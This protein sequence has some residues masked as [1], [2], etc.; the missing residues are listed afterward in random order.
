MAN[1]LYGAG[2][3]LMECLRLRVQDI[4]FASNQITVRDGK[5]NKD[6][7]TMLPNVLKQPLRVHL[8]N[9]RKTHRQDLTEEY[10]RVYMPYA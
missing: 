2:L 10:G 3:R 7:V 9:V 8:K 1:L 5:G 6:R 4:D